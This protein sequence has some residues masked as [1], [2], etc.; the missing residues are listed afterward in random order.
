MHNLVPARGF[1]LIEILV[2]LVI[3]GVVLATVVVKVLPDDRQALQQETSRLA[4]LLEHARDEAFVSGRSIAW[5]AEDGAYA[6]WRRDQERKWQPLTGN[7]VLR[8]RHFPSSVILTGLTINR[9][10]VATSERLIFSPSGLNA[11]FE[12]VLVLH[13]QRLV[14]A[15]DNTGRVKVR[16]DK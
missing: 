8:E 4:L 12:A 1:T 15:G 16:D 5:S 14:L 10:E 9:V 11:P 7:E 2:V 6:F 3:V 13:D